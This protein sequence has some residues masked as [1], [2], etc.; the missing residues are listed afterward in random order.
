MKLILENWRNY[1]SEEEEEE[2]THEDKLKELFQHHPKQALHIAE[3]VDID[4]EVVAAM[5]EVVTKVRKIM[6]IYEDSV[7]APDQQKALEVEGV[8]ELYF[9]FERALRTIYG[10]KAFDSSVELHD[11]DSMVYKLYGI[12][13]YANK[14]HDTAKKMRMMKKDHPTYKKV[15]E[16][17]GEPQ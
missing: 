7:N 13:N 17:L 8:G 10:D 16:W 4:P 6:K 1:L 3:Q 14:Y 9:E 2:Q 15:A 12:A 11:I 5:K